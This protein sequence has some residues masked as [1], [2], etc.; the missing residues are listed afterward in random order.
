MDKGVFQYGNYY[1]LYDGKKG[2][3]SD[4]DT[5]DNFSCSGNGGTG[6]ETITE[7]AG[8]YDVNNNLL[9]TWDELVNNYGFD[10]IGM[11][12]WDADGNYNY[13]EE[14]S[15][16][17]LFNSNE[18]LTKGTKLVIDNSI[19]KIGTA[20]F[21]DCENLE[22]III[23]ESVI[24]IGESSF[25][26][27]G[28]TS[29]VIPNSVTTIGYGAFNSCENLTEVVLSN[30]VTK[31]EDETFSNCLNL[32]KV[33]FQKGLTVIGANAFNYSG[34]ENIV[35]PETVSIVGEG[36]FS[37]N[38]NLASVTIPK[39]VSSIGKYAFYYDEKLATINYTGSE[40]E[41]NAI[42][43]GE[44][45]NYGFPQDNKINYNYVIN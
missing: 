9:Y 43:F 3:I 10:V 26:C 6:N 42:T 16:R 14:E 15:L 37:G 33:E 40:T 13:E 44:D 12:Y 36:A 28:I 5:Y 20:A 19:T 25:E 8:L 39:S 18:D 41:W 27:S 31:I 17:S 38:E 32:E 2:S 29:I 1:V 45:W 30:K 4:K 21:A 34:L 22:F 11:D 7:A 35:L 24:S 23:P